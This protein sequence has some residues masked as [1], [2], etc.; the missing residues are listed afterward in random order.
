MG[1]LW[2]EPWL[3]VALPILGLCDGIYTHDDGRLSLGCPRVIFL[4]IENQFHVAFGASGFVVA[5][6]L[7]SIAA[8]GRG[9]LLFGRTEC[10]TG[11]TNLDPWKALI[12]VL[13]RMA[14]QISF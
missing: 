8:D 5:G 4:P 13:C 9:E 10:I 6:L 7:T 1:F 11:V 2:N 12:T 3:G 14:L